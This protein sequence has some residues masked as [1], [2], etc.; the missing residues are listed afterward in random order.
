MTGCF[1]NGKAAVFGAKVNTDF[2]LSLRKLPKFQRPLE[3]TKKI[4]RQNE[5]RI[6][7][8]QKIRFRRT[9]IR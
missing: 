8:N 2:F 1:I 3:P 6:A 4:Q 5:N 7:V 9:C